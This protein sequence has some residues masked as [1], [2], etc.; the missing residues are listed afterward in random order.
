MKRIILLFLL[1]IP[2]AFAGT[3]FFDIP[4]DSFIMGESVTGGAI[5]TEEQQTNEGGC[6]TNWVCSS[7]SSCINGIQARNCTKE[8]INCYADL[9]K[10][11]VENQSCFTKIQN[12]TDFE[13]EI[14]NLS[15]TK[16]MF[17][18]L[19]TLILAIGFMV[20]FLLKKLRKRR[21]LR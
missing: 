7:W 11:P 15:N 21:Y 19:I 20:F 1:L 2:L 10:K 16:I 9:K 17:L 4:D 12:N 3:T 13:G 5:I 18:V 14:N 6:L 8:K